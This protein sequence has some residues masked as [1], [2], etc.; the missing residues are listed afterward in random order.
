MPEMA[1]VKVVA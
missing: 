1:P